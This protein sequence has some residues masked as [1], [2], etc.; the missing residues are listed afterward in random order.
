MGNLDLPVDFVNRSAS[1][2]VLLGQPTIEGVKADGLLV[3]LHVTAG[4]YFGDPG[5][6]SNIAPGQVAAL[7]ISGVTVCSVGTIYPMFRIG[8]PGGGSIEIPAKNFPVG[9]GVWVSDFGVPADAVPVT[10]APLSPLTATID[11]PATVR[12]GTTLMFTVTLANQ[13]GSDYVLNPCPRYVEFVGSG[14]TSW[15]ATVDNYELNCD[16]TPAIR[17]GSSV[18]FEMVLALP[19]DQPAGPAKF[20]WDLQGDSGPFAGAQLQILAAGD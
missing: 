18:T 15:V 2:C 16:A 9:C 19:S 5:P 4:C 7:N 1:P 6:P 12:A 10:D 20:G 17:A 11:V 13:T 3:G 14:S 8:L